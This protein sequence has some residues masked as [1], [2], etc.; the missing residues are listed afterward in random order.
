MVHG[1]DVQG[2]KLRVDGHSVHIVQLIVK[3]YRLIIDNDEIDFGVGDT[4]R[5]NGILYGRM[6]IKR[7]L[8]AAFTFVPGQKIVQLFIES[9]ISA[10]G[11]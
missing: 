11:F 9:E 2:L 7:H 8:K 10:V 4:Q 5:F 3:S 1:L 6:L